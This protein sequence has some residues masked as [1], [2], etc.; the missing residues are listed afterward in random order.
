[1]LLKNLLKF[2]TG[3]YAFGISVGYKLVICATCV[4]TAASSEQAHAA[5]LS[6][7][8]LVMLDAL[9]YG[10]ILLMAKCKFDYKESDLLRRI[11]ASICSKKL[12]RMTAVFALV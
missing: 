11:S 12:R 1:M 9:W 3:K 6:C 2:A 4:Q 7:A 5:M 10:G 8:F